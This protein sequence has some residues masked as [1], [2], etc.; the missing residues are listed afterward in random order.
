MIKKIFAVIL[1]MFFCDTAYASN[2]A[3]QTIKIKVEAISVISVSGDPG[4]LLISDGRTSATDDST[5]Y[6]ITTNEIGKKIMAKVDRELPKGLTLKVRLDPPE[7]AVSNEIVLST[8]PRDVVTGISKVAVDNMKIHYTL[9]VD[10]R[11]P[12]VIENS[13]N[14]IF[15]IVD[16]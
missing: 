5:T 12:E 3:T 8:I 14:V 1:M 15:T 7:G 16:G 6:A 9:T 10:E 13:T 2:T 4:M 11:L